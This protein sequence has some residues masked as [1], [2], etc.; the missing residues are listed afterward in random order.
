MGLGSKPVEVVIEDLYLLVVPAVGSHTN[1]EEDKR[2]AQ[3]A[4]MQRLENAELL[5]SR[6]AADVAEDAQKNQGFLQALVGTILNN[7]QITVKNIHIR[8]E[9]KSSVPGHPFAAGV[10]LAEFSAR[11]TDGKWEPA[12]VPSNAGTIFKVRIFP[13]GGCFMSCNSALN[14]A[15][16]SRIARVIFQHGRGEHIR[17][18]SGPTQIHIQ[19]ARMYCP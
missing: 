14:P 2:R 12:F 9:D 1:P 19:V 6:G 7:L 8:Y 4:K 15:C 16:S 5:Q 13:F 3:E 10:T 18:Q 17:A 11:T